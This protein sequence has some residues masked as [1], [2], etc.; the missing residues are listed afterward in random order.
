MTLAAFLLSLCLGL[1]LSWLKEWRILVTILDLINGTSLNHIV[2]FRYLKFL[3]S[4]ADSLVSF[5]RI[6]QAVSRYPTLFE[7]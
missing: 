5:L 4:K 7:Q 3:K 6:I 1:F 2:A